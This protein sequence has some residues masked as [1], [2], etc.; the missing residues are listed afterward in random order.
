MFQ[1]SVKTNGIGSRLGF[2]IMYR[3][4]RMSYCHI[5]TTLYTPCQSTFRSV[6]PPTIGALR[7][8]LLRP[9]L[10]PSLCPF[11]L[12][13]PPSAKWPSKTQL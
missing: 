11:P 10:P 8:S 5:K 9:P 6:D 12:P 13:S 4:L 1:H 2:I 7:Q 3:L